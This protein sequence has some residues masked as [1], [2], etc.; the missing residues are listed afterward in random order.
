MTRFDDV[1]ACEARSH[2]SGSR[3]ASVH[4]WRDGTLTLACT[5]AWDVAV[6]LVKATL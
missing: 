6:A 1:L 3:V 5:G 2:A 4:V